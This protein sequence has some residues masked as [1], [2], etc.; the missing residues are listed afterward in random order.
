MLCL[1]RKDFPDLLLDD[2]DLEAVVELWFRWHRMAPPAVLAIVATGYHRVEGRLWGFPRQQAESL[3][4]A[5]RA[6]AASCGL[7]EVQVEQPDPDTLTVSTRYL[8]LG[9]PCSLVA[10]LDCFAAPEFEGL[11]LML[12]LSLHEWRGQPQGPPLAGSTIALC[13]QLQGGRL[14]LKAAWPAR[15]VPGQERLYEK[16]RWQGEER[17]LR[18]VRAYPGPSDPPTGYEVLFGSR[19]HQKRAHWLASWIVDFPGEAKLP[20]FLRRVG[21]FTA[22]ILLA[23]ALLIWVPMD[24]LSKILV[25][26]WAVLCGKGLV[27]VVYRKARLVVAYYTRMRAAFERLYTQDPCFE[28]IDLAAVGAWPD[29]HACKYSAELQALGCRHYMDVRTNA[30]SS[31]TSCI[32]VFVLPEE[33]T[34]LNLLL[35]YVTSGNQL[36]LFPARATLLVTT[37]LVWDRRLVST[38]TDSVGYRKKRDPRLVARC[39]PGAE[40]PATLLEKHRKVLRRLLGEADQ[41]APL[42]GPQGLLQ[43]LRQDHEEA[44]ELARRYGY[45]SWGAALRAAF[46]LPRREY[47][48]AQP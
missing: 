33:R 29:P 8:D 41:L 31:G 13:G 16:A 46:K 36:R 42:L 10:L 9:Q 20:G 34:Y 26:A 24:W 35:L 43:R 22:F 38:D 48:E 30:S 47:L 28:E 23:V 1:T 40:D 21:F 4:Q 12:R 37:Y 19:R 11:P 25:A 15:L 27:Y 17:F 39:F 5:L 18:A 2:H 32:R 6:A 45:Y 14:L 7:P 3:Q 44:A